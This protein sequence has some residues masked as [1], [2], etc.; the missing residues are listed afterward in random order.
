MKMRVWGWLDLSFLFNKK[1]KEASI[2]WQNI[3]TK[4]SSRPFLWKRGVHK[5]ALKFVWIFHV[6]IEIENFLFTRNR[7]FSLRSHLCTNRASISSSAASGVE[8]LRLDSKIRSTCGEK[9]NSWWNGST[10][11]V[12]IQNMWGEVAVVF[13]FFYRM[14]KRVLNIRT[15]LLSRTKKSICL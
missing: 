5:C 10:T 9:R 8:P 12:A 11:N 4:R 6:L 2:L 14:H 1:I 15:F 3:C 7:Y 13:Q